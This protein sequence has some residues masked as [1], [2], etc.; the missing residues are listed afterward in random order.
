[1]NLISFHRFLIACAIL[2]C[3]GFAAWELDRYLE[4][5]AGAALALA[6]AFGLLAA[7][8]IVYLIRLNAFLG[9]PPGTD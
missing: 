7:A 9:R 3:G 8:L 4:G 2:F 5:S 6:V 1:V